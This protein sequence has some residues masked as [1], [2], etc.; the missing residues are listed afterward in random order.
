MSTTVLK[1][2]MSELAFRP[3]TGGVLSDPVP[4]KPALFEF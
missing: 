2:I 1:S 3:L 4:G